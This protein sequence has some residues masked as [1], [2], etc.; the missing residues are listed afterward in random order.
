MVTVVT[1]VT[2]MVN[3]LVGGGCPYTILYILLLRIDF[4]SVFDLLM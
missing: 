1:V 4:Y 3:D 2:V